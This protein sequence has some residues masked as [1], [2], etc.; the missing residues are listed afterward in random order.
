MHTTD[1]NNLRKVYDLG[2]GDTDLSRVVVLV[3]QVVAD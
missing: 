3:V 2:I 1:G